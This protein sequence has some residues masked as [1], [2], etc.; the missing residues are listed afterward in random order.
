V[1]RSLLPLVTAVVQAMQ[2]SKSGTGGDIVLNVDG[3]TLARIMKPYM[4]QENK[5][6]GSNIRLQSI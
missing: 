2:F 1:T 4:D 6:V 5:R 3:R